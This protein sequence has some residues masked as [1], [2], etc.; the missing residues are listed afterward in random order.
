MNRILAGIMVLFISILFIVSCS[1]PEDEKEISIVGSTT[2][3]PIMQKVA[4]DYMNLHE[5]V[6]LTVSGGGSGVGVTALLDGTCDIAMSSRSMKDEEWEK[7]KES[8]LDVE[9]VEITKD[10]IAIILHPSNPVE[11]LTMVQVH[12]IYVGEI[13]NWKEVGG[14]DQEIVVVS[15][16][17]SSGTFE[18][19]N[20]LVLKKDPLREDALMQASNAAVRSA[21]EGSEA[22]IG[23]IGIGYITDNIKTI[24]ID[25]VKPSE[26]AVLS[27]DYPISRGLYLYILKTAPEGVKELVKFVLGDEGQKIVEEVGYIPL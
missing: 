20:K 17:S 27:G 14:P 13:K 18:A 23:Y 9:E 10:G 8:G 15:R 25:G 6:V 24:K 26:E 3:L 7:A 5:E 21:V 1:P 12:D 22:S 16:D 11:E 4:E 19:F 2:V